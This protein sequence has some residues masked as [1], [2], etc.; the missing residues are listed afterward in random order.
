[1]KIYK[2]IEQDIDERLALDKRRD[3]RAFSRC[4]ES[5]ERL[6]AGFYD[7]QDKIRNDLEIEFWT[8]FDDGIDRSKLASWKAP[9]NELFFF[10]ADLIHCEQIRIE[11]GKEILG[12]K[13]IGL[14]MSYLEKCPSRYSM[15][16]AVYTGMEKGSEYLGR[17]VINSE[18][19]AVES[20][21][22][23]VWYKQ[24]RF[25]EIEVSA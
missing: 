8:N 13:L 24:V 4:F 21:L 9:V 20:S 7:L 10:S 22:C 17:F 14:I 15:V 1:M 25:I 23:D 3:T 16:V 2:L 12:D 18:E 11:I 6:P 19:I 5:G